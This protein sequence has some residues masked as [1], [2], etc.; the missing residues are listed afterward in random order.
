MSM[1]IKPTPEIKAE[2]I[3]KC[4]QQIESMS[5]F[6]GTFKIELSYK[7]SDN[8]K[9]RVT[10]TPLAWRKQKRLVADFT[11]EVGWHGV[12]KRDPEDP[13]H[14]IVEDI[15][16]FPQ[17]VTGATVTPSQ[18]EYD[19]W[20][21][22]LPDEQFN[23]LRFHGHSHVNMDVN[24]S[25]TDTTYQ[26]KL[27]DGI[28]GADFTAEERAAVLEA[29]G[30]TCFYIFMIMNK[31]G[32][33]WIRIRDMFYNI[34]YAP[35]EIEVIHEAEIDELAAFMTD[36]KNKVHSYTYNSNKNSNKGSSG[37]NWDWW[38][39]NKS[40]QSSPAIPAT[41]APSA[42]Q[43]QQKTHGAVENSMNDADHSEYPFGCWDG[44]KWV[45]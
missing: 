18:E 3:E 14:F 15:I 40:P 7:Y 33:F 45:I 38:R 9:A 26:K 17:A 32:K 24:P 10:F 20:K 1:P 8:D 36:A 41:S 5:A 13:A 21:G 39:N 25:G 19:M 12:C 37:Q 22:M 29:M 6:N 34:E 2:L 31:S 30:D 42:T 11:T 27:S 16:I 44:N 43:S 28:E 4:I 35:N 23:N